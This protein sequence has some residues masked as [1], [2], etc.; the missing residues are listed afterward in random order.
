MLLNGCDLAIVEF[1]DAALSKPAIEV[2]NFIAHLRLLSVQEPGDAQA[3]AH[4]TATFTERYRTLDPDLLRFLEAATLVQL[5][6]IH[7]PRRRGAVIAA[8][9]LRASELLL[10]REP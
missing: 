7:L 10:T 4:T 2:A 9:L 8:A 1:D 3:L 5:A 6:A